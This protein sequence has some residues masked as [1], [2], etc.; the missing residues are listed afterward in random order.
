MTCKDNYTVSAWGEVCSLTIIII[1]ST[2]CEVCVE[3]RRKNE[4]A[5]K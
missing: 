1:H 4:K 3:L 2:N 5:I